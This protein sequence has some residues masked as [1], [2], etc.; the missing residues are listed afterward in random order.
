MGLNTAAGG[1]G[2]KRARYIVPLQEEKDGM[3]G[4]QD[5]RFQ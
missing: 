4:W 1:L 5:R 2:I 3:T